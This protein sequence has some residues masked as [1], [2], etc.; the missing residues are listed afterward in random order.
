MQNSVLCNLRFGSPKLAAIDQRLVVSVQGSNLLTRRVG[1][2]LDG[3]AT[4]LSVT[5]LT[6]RTARKDNM[7]KS[8]GSAPWA[9]AM[10]GGGVRRWD[11]ITADFPR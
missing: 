1:D 6:E 2:G 9:R 5:S 8:F 10:L 3:R 11:R 4:Q 7:V